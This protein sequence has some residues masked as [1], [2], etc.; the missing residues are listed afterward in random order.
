MKLEKI[1]IVMLFL[2]NLSMLLRS[3]RLPQHPPMPYLPA[4]IPPRRQSCHF[5]AAKRRRLSC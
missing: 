1:A 3:T 5:L 4:Q 2:T